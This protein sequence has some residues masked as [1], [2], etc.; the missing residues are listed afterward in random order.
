MNWGPGGVPGAAAIVSEPAR[1]PS[2]I[3]AGWVGKWGLAGSRRGPNL[4]RGRHCPQG[5]SVSRGPRAPLSPLVP[6]CAA[7]CR[8]MCGDK[9]AHTHGAH[10]VYY[11]LSPRQASTLQDS[12][13][14]FNKSCPG[15]AGFEHPVRK[16]R[17]GCA[18]RAF[19]IIG[20]QGGGEGDGCW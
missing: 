1:V 16:L 2:V 13:H 17:C 4:R 14:A 20:S 18:F 11:R 19:G 15:S 7:D 3:S 5:A 10:H 6:T 12:S 8:G 9:P